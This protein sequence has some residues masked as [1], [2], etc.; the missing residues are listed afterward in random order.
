MK[1]Y[2]I[3]LYFIIFFVLSSQCFA[4]NTVNFD[5]LLKNYVDVKGPGVSVI[6]TKAGQTIYKGARGKANIELQR[7]LPLA[8]N[9]NLL[10]SQNNL[11]A[12]LY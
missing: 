9:L 2:F 1:S 12:Q 7:F 3:R 5:K 10:Q 8:V 11:P 4:S 6:V